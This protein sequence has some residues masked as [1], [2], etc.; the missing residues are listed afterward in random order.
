MK[1]TVF[2]TVAILAL[3]G[4]F[5]GTTVF[6]QHENM[7]ME[8]MGGMKME[9][10]KGMKHDCMTKNKDGKMCDKQMMDK[11]QMK[12]SKSDCK[13]MMDHAMMPTDAKTK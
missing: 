1:D 7:N 9:D 6:A 11:C 12:M 5:L 2:R 8:N 13:K 4:S 10:M 3:L